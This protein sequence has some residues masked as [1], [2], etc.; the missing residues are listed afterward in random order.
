M[1]RARRLGV[2]AHRHVVGDDRDLGLEIDAPG[3]VGHRDR[4][5]R[6]EERVGAALVHQRIGPEARRHLRAARLAHQ[7][8]VVHVGRAVGPLIGARQG[9]GAFLGRELARRRAIRR[10]P[11]GRASSRSSGAI[12]A[13]SSSACCRVVAARAVT[14]RVRSRLTTTQ[15]AVAAAGLQGRELHALSSGCLPAVDI[16]GIS[17]RAGGVAHLQRVARVDHHGVFVG[18]GL[19]RLEGMF[20]SALGCGPWVKPQGWNVIMPGLMLSRLKKSPA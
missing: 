1:W 14:Q 10:L 4:I 11:A 18:R 6:A 16:A 8:D 5:A 9:R 12:S 19:G 17:T 15:A 13:Q 7:L 20:F 2:D 3:L